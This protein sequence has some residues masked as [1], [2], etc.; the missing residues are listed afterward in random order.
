MGHRGCQHWCGE[1]KV[2]GLQGSVWQDNRCLSTEFFREAMERASSDEGKWK[3]HRAVWDGAK[4]QQPQRNLVVKVFQS[5]VGNGSGNGLRSEKSVFSSWFSSSSTSHFILA[6]VC[7]S[8]C[9]VKVN[10]FLL[11]CYLDCKLFFCFRMG[12][13]PHGSPA[14]PSVSLSYKS[15][16][17]ITEGQLQCK[18]QERSVWNRYFCV[19]PALQLF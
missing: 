4:V 17:S 8:I 7:F 1:Q 16:V 6:V 5:C 11:L 12:V 3:A 19:E 13:R 14:D 9:C 10:P 15:L 2:A 18:L